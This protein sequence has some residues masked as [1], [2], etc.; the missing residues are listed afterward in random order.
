VKVIKQ[1]EDLT[2]ARFSCEPLMKGYGMTIGNS[3]RRILLSSLKGTAVIAVK[4]KGVEHEFTTIPGIREDVVDIILNIKQIRF[5]ATQDKLHHIVLRKNTC[6][7]VTAGDIEDN[8]VLKV[9]NKDLVLCNLD[10]DTEIEIEFLLTS[11]RGYVQAEDHDS[12]LYTEGY[13]PVDSFF[14]PVLNVNY[15]ITGARVKNSFNYDKLVFDIETDGSITARDAL[16]YAAMILREHTKFFINFHV[17]EQI[18]EKTRETTEEVNW[19]LYKTIDDMDLSVRSHN[20]LKNANIKYVGEL[21]QRSEGEMLKTKNFGRKSL[22]EIKLI[23]LNMGLHFGMHVEKFPDP[24][25]LEEIEK[26][27]KEQISNE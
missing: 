22:N 10:E 17:E 23:L 4:I 11:G 20:C 16:A 21:V 2:E 26:C 18:I 8:S 27:A 14:S 13:I 15:K 5:V 7:P 3:L 9:L 24:K 1:N 12:E 6:G 25:V 19:N